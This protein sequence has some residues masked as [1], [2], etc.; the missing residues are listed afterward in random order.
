MAAK[1]EKEMPLITAKERHW[2]SDALIANP[3]LVQAIGLAPVVA[4][5]TS[6]R[7]A[8][9]IAVVAGVHLLL[10][11]P[12][13]SLLLRR[14]PAW[15]R[16]AC[17]YVL[18][19]ALVVPL[20]YV[21]RRM[22]DPIVAAM[23]IFLP[24]LAINSLAAVRCE[25]FAV[26]HN[27][28]ACLKDAAATAVG[29]GTVTV[30]VG[31]IREFLGHGSFLGRQ[32]IT[33]DVRG[34]WMPFGGFLVV[35]VL[36]A[37]LKLLLRTLSEHGIVVG[38]HKAMELAPEDREVRREKTRKLFEDAET[39]RQVLSAAGVLPPENPPEEAKTEPQ[40][41]EP[42]PE[43]PAHPKPIPAEAVAEAEG[44]KT[45]AALPPELRELEETEFGGLVAEAGYADAE[46][47][48]EG[49]AAAMEALEELEAL[50]ELEQEESK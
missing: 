48:S 22:D 3:V 39:R 31:V 40:A 32:V 36:A 19:L 14:L 50:D 9:V 38:A 43:E 6:L 29:Y 28:P 12:L 11:E 49:V 13:T 26:L 46:P 21:L 5:A 47:V 4:V 45:A 35:G 10:C 23:D 20:Q 2:L 16:V 37:G 24:L 34:I 30:L 42:P 41:A 27:T 25:R 1:K 15:L 8:L 18:G 17:Y 33:F 44:K 7:A